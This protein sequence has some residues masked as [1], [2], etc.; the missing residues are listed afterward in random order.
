[1]HSE[2]NY[3]SEVGLP[4]PR[5]CGGRIIYNGNYFCCYWD[6][7]CD[8]AMSHGWNGNPVGVLDN[9]TWKKIQ[10]SPWYRRATNAQLHL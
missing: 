3:G 1:M 9:V 5:H 6:M 2:E 4:C 7:G 8:W 10:A